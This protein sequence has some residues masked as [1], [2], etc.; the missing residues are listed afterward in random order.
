MLGP[1][2]QK[3]WWPNQTELLPDPTSGIWQTNLN[4]GGSAGQAHELLIGVVDDDGHR[5]IQRLIQDTPDQPFINSLPPGFTQL[6]RVLV[7]K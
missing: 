1:V 3:K 6:A 2:G 5:R 4:L 7:M